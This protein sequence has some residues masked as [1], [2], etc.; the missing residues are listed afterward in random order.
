VL[1]TDSHHVSPSVL[2]FFDH[3]RYLFNVGEGLQRH[4]TSHKIS[5]NK[6]EHVLATRVCTSTLSG[7]PGMLLSTK[8]LNPTSATLLG[9]DSP[10][11]LYGEAGAGLSCCFRTHQRCCAPPQP[12][13]ARIASALPLGLAQRPSSAPAAPQQRPSSAP[14]CAPAGPPGVGQYV[15]AFRPYIN[16]DIAVQAVE[17]QASGSKPMVKTQ[18][19]VPWAP[20]PGPLYRQQDQAAGPGV[21]CSRG[22]A[23]AAGGKVRPALHCLPPQVVTITP[24]VITP[25]QQ[26]QQ[27]QQQ[28]QE[29]ASGAGSEAE[30]ADGPERK[31]QRTQVGG[32]PGLG[33]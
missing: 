2:L 32:A 24:I 22:R 3:E 9:Q 16:D 13:A 8:G 11:K 14:A 31:R 19:G 33:P 26:A 23:G 21:G 29:P 25:Q 20:G 10:T 4:L 1:Q 17:A 28:A 5:M 6:I 7:L 15:E 12:T 30:A 27:E 18:V